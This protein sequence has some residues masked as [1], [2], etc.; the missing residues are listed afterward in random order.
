MNHLTN[1]TR[2]EEI[3]RLALELMALHGLADWRFS[4]NNRKRHLGLC[5]FTVRTIELSVYFVERNGL[6]EI[7]D[8]IL[9][10]IAHALVGPGHGHDRVW[11][12]KCLEV[13][14]RP[15]RCIRADMPRGR[16]QVRCGGCGRQFCR[17]RKPKVRAGLH[18]RLCGPEQG[19]LLWLVDDPD[20]PREESK[21]TT[22]PPG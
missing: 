21:T 4:F 8:T 2:R 11:K 7:R 15:Q 20:G 13:G 19:Q 10:E 3:R 5:R 16:W 14:A 18:C 6:D 22:P 1:Q 9:H 12:Q 17:H